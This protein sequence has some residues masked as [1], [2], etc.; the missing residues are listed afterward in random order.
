MKRKVS[1]IVVIVAFPL[2]LY[3]IYNN[4]LNKK[5]NAFD[6][7]TLLTEM[8][9]FNTEY[10]VDKSAK[11]DLFSVAPTMIFLGTDKLSVYEYRN[12]KS[13]EKDAAR[14]SSDGYQI[15]NNKVSWALE[16]H[17]FKKGKILVQYCGDNKKTFDLLEKIL[18]RQ[19]AGRK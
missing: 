13:M 16:P 9:S 19:F 10:S 1:I 3:L 8:N 5:D 7:E 14:I 15:G 18:G 11:R 2:I 6:T 12:I 17:F 4:T